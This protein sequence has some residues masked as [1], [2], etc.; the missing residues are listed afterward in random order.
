MVVK[1]AYFVICIECRTAYKPNLKKKIRVSTLRFY[2][3]LTSLSTFKTF[4][5]K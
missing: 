2:N 1:T 3:M 5:T 4:N